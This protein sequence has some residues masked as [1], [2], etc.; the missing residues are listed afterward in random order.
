MEEPNN[1]WNGVQKR[2]NIWICYCKRKTYGCNN[3]HTSGFNSEWQHDPRTF[4]LPVDHNYWS[5]TGKTTPNHETSDSSSGGGGT[6]GS[7]MSALHTLDI[8]GLVQLYQGY[9]SHSNFISFL[10]DLSELSDGL[11]WLG[12]DYLTGVAII[13]CFL[14][15]IYDKFVCVH[16]TA[17]SVCGYFILS[18]FI[19]TSPTWSFLPPPALSTSET[20]SRLE[21]SRFYQLSDQPLSPQASTPSNLTGR[22]FLSIASLYNSLALEE[23]DRIC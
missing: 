10:P 14:P 7:G 18:L 12:T 2:E 15:V 13:I 19:F 16:T 23:E 3:T 20:C 4:C 17:M 9:L 21:T 11:K 22:I 5:F 8:Y 6:Q 1:I